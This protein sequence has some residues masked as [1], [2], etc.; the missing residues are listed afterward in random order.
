VRKGGSLDLKEGGE[1]SY[2]GGLGIVQLLG[3]MEEDRLHWGGDGPQDRGQCEEKSEKVE[4]GEQTQ[5]SVLPREWKK[6]K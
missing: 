5:A 4:E 6:R 3:G 1:G 2:F